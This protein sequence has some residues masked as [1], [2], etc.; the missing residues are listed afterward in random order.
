[1]SAR[2]PSED[3]DVFGERFAVDHEHR[4]LRL[5]IDP[6]VL[7]V[8]L[9]LVLERDR[10]HVELRARLVQGHQRNER[11]GDRGVI[12]SEFHERPSF[13][14]RAAAPSPSKASASR[15]TAQKAGYSQPPSLLVKSQPALPCTSTIV[16]SMSGTSANATQRVSM[17]RMSR[18]PPTIS[19]AIVRYATSAGRPSDLKYW[20]VP[21]G[22]KTLTFTQA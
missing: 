21:E 5:G 3:R 14:P 17:P 7:G 9:L 2:Q 18:T 1:K 6:Q 11:A 16:P 15:P 12:E 10:P 8:V 20:A 13:G 22:V 19:A 4:H